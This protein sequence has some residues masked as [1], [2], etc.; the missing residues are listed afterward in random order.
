[1]IR[2][3]RGGGP[4]TGSAVYSF[5]PDVTEQ[6]LSWGTHTARRV[7]PV[8]Q[9][10]SAPGEAAQDA[11]DGLDAGFGDL[12][13]KPDGLGDRVVALVSAGLLGL[14]PAGLGSAG[15]GSLRLWGFWLWT[16]AGGGSRR[17]RLCLPGRART[18]ARLRARARLPG[19]ARARARLRSRGCLRVRR[20]RAPCG[21][22]LRR[23]GRGGRAAAAAA[24]A[25][26]ALGGRGTRRPV[27][28]F[29]PARAPLV[30]AH[31][32]TRPRQ[33]AQHSRLVAAVSGHARKI[34]L[35]AAGSPSGPSSAP[36]RAPARPAHS[37]RGQD[38]KERLT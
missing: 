28:G 15:L 17:L 5:G 32:R 34:A 24:R 12:A 3:R 11:A 33:V 29:P 4:L 19:R 16:A 10:G 31:A 20:L 37:T 2:Q 6:G 26:A 9:V 30:A 38:R 14:G 36:N 18:R 8:A 13:G 25:R 35:P 1:M 7:A 27:A 23:P 22:R 21:G